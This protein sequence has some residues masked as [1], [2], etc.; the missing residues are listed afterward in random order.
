M[1]Q[2]LWFD[3]SN[4]NYKYWYLINKNIHSVIATK[5]GIV[6]TKN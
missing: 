2:V 1:H 4:E 3:D 6:G 5:F